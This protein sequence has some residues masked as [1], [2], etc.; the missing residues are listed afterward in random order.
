MDPGL[1]PL[2]YLFQCRILIQIEFWENNLKKDLS[3]F[4]CR[5][6]NTQC[7]PTQP[8]GIKQTCLYLGS[9]IKPTFFWIN[10]FRKTI[11]NFFFNFNQFLKIKKPLWSR[12]LR[13]HSFKKIKSTSFTDTSH[14]LL[15]KSFVKK[16]LY[17]FKVVNNLY[18][19][20]GGCDP[21][22]T[23]PEFS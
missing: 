21:L 13:N 22:F 20:G 10:D 18:P 11:Q 4:F 9:I 19:L 17:N 14:K 15:L 8:K 16:K 6:L 23:K 7:D 12:S 5:L 1:A 2:F 3:L